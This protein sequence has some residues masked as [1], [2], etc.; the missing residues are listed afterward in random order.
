MQTWGKYQAHG[1]PALGNYRPASATTRL[2][3]S[4]FPVINPLVQF[5]IPVALCSYMCAGLIFQLWKIWM[6][7]SVIHL[8]FSFLSLLA[9]MCWIG[10]SSWKIWTLKFVF[11]RALLNPLLLLSIHCKVWSILFESSQRNVGGVI[12]NSCP[13]PQIRALNRLWTLTG[14]T[15]GQRIEE[16]MMTEYIYC[17]CKK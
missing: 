10:I 7:K 3:L 14:T 6:L 13:V 5:L 12:C 15:Q 11:G 9:P 16:I 17:H 2:D 8:L 1:A 4:S